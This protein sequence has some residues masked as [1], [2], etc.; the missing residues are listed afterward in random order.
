MYKLKGI[1]VLTLLTLLALAANAQQP[2]NP[3]AKSG[4]TIQ[5]R[6]QADTDQMAADLGLNAAQ[7]E[8]LQQ[9][10]EERAQK[11]KE[12]RRNRDTK[13]DV[14]QEERKQALKEA[15]KA[16]GKE[17]K[18]GLKKILT[19]EQFKKWREMKASKSKKPKGDN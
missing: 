1:F 2:N 17:Y 19:D 4:N 12:L 18:T 10:N 6:V 7:K 16:I 11:R 8:S 3:F 13:E 9:L 14:S 5:Q 15:K